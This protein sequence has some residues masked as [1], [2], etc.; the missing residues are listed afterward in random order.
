MLPDLRFILGAALGTIVLSVTIFGL[1]SSI[2]LA[3][4]ARMAGPFEG[5][6]ALAYTAQGE[7]GAQSARRAGDLVQEPGGPFAKMPLGGSAIA[8]A[9]QEPETAAA[10]SPSDAAT[11]ESADSHAAVDERAVV[12]PPLSPTGEPLPE[13][14]GDPPREPTH[15]EQPPAPAEEPAAEITGSLPA[16]AE[17]TGSL[18]AAA[19]AVQA[20]AEPVPD[21]PPAKAKKAAPKKA[22]AKRRARPAV[23]P[24]TATTGYPV[25]FPRTQNSG[26]NPFPFLD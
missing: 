7:S 26:N 23:I 20:E 10:P 19:E 9:P 1:A 17:A 2:R 5:S 4:E 22:K 14:D 6:R 16:P 11:G 8:Q 13:P 21:V 25:L 18:P 3:H 12:D 24:P 15:A